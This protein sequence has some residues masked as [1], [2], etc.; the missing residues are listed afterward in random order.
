MRNVIVV[1]IVAGIVGCSSAS[2]PTN[3]SGNA[4]AN[5]LSV[6]GASEES[7]ARFIHDASAFSPA[8][9]QSATVGNAPPWKGP[10][11]YVAPTS[12]GVLYVY[13]GAPHAPKKTLYS[14]SLYPGLENSLQVD[15][16]QNLYFAD[17]YS[18]WVYEYAPGTNTPKK[19]FPTSY[20]P[21]NISVRG[22][23]LYVFQSMDSGG[24]ASIAVYEGGRTHPT[25]VLSDASITYPQGMAVDKAGNVFVGYGGANF[26]SGIG[27]FVR[28]KGT[29]KQL[30][31]SVDPLS[32]AID[33]AGNLLVDV[34]ATESESAIDVFPP[35]STSPSSSIKHL[36][37]M[38]Q[39]SLTA[40][41]KSFYAGDMGHVKK[42]QM[43]S[44]PSG[45]LIYSFAAPDAFAGYA[46]IAASP[47]SSVGTW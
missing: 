33:P 17:S 2:L 38:Y 43:Y 20:R 10:V 4:P 45:K 15:D 13:P 28:G 36:P 44:Y 22:N 37:W 5:G 46:G 16:R 39:F 3:T 9:T 27:E 19:S 35:G 29:M 40:D 25:R 14:F 8:V 31:Q 32:L 21:S 23:T 47:A 42:Y 24:Y 41:G 6:K 1:F 7:A 26:T 12:R 18:T 34:I 30:N 11:V